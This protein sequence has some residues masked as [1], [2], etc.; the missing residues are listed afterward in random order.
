[1]R[2]VKHGGEYDAI[3]SDELATQRA[4]YDLWLA[5]D[6]QETIQLECVEVPWLDVNQKIRYKSF[7]TGE[8]YEYIV[9]SKSGSTTGGTMSITCNKFKPL[10]SWL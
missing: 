2:D 6:L 4:K 7:R 3:Y 1:M 9:L 10:Y 5:S 8:E